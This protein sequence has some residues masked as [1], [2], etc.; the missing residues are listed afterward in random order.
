M[1][2]PRQ[3]A[4]GGTVMPTHLSRCVAHDPRPKA[5]PE[6]EE[7]AWARSRVISGLVILTEWSG[8]ILA[9]CRCCFQMAME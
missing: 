9:D 8:I 7:N 4:A 3:A 5:G 2:L 6:N 1:M